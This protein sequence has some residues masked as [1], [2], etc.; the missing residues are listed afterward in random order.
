MIPA[1]LNL[2]ERILCDYIALRLVFSGKIKFTSFPPENVGRYIYRIA[3]GMMDARRHAHADSFPPPEELVYPS[4]LIATG[5][6]VS[7][8]MSGRGRSPY[9]E[10]VQSK[11]GTDSHE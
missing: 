6:A 5:C 1:K 9:S 10:G 11:E 2:R 4:D 8:Q 3:R 7:L